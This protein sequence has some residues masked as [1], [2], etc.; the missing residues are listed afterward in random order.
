MA[1]QQMVQEG[2][3]VLR[4]PTGGGVGG[5]RARLHALPVNQAPPHALVEGGLG[6]GRARLRALS[7]N[8]APPHALVEG[9]GGVLK[10]KTRYTYQV[11]RQG[12]HT[13]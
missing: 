12:T 1:Q 10:P 11:T 2:A 13:R 6:G 8:Q 9:G 3:D 5:G 7:V 4:F